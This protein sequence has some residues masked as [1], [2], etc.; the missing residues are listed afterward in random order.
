MEFA[1]DNL[2]VSDS[3]ALD[4]DIAY[5]GLFT[6]YDADIDVDGVTLNSDLYRV[7]L[8]EEVTVIHIHRSDVRTTGVVGEICLENGFVVGVSFVDAKVLSQGFG[9]VDSIARESDVTEEERSALV[10]LDVYFNAI[11]FFLLVF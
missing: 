9:R 5:T 4:Y 2:V 1:V 11:L 8:E 3:V 10:Y 6:L 7:Y